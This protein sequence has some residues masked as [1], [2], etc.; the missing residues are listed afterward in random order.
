MSFVRRHAFKIA[1]LAL[2]AAMA[3]YLLWERNASANLPVI[4]QA[5]DYKLAAV[6]GGE[7]TLSD[8]DGKVRLYYFFF[9]NCPDVCP[10]TTALMSDVQ[11]ELKAR[12]EFG[13]RVTFHW[14]TMDPE[15]DT[16]EAMEAFADGYSADLAGWS[17]LRGGA[18]ETVELAKQFGLLVNNAGGPE[19][20]VHADKLVLVDA[21]G[22]IR[23]YIA[24]S[25]EQPKEEILADIAAALEG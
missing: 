18:E 16:L 11:D 5:P 10:I 12:G 19:S 24:G 7:E 8:T 20:L 25:G 4:K 22:Q 6:G 15:R 2:C 23:K 13:S 9:T 1:V 21:K 3:G 17:F 14:I